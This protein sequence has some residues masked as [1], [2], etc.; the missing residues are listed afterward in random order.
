MHEFDFSAEGFR[1]ID[2]NDTQQ[3]TVSLIR[4]GRSARNTLIVAC[5]FTPIPRHNYRLGAP[6][7]GIWLE[8]LNSDAKDYG[9][10]GQGNLGV[11]ES[12]PVPS[13]GFSYSLNLTLPPLAAV[14]LKMRGTAE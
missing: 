12:A 3:S 9:G 7:G 8:I 1:W 13:H 6:G 10:S 5:N 11:L 4:S 14:F 2:C